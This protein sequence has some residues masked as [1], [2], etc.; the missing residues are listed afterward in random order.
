MTID[1]QKLQQN[2]QYANLALKAKENVL[3]IVEFDAI[4]S[5]TSAIIEEIYI[6]TFIFV[7]SIE[8]ASSTRRQS[9]VDTLELLKH[10]CVR[11]STLNIFDV[12]LEL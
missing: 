10:E 7:L 5:F 8:F 9:I 3:S 1:L 4:D 2:E 6:T 11:I 12:I